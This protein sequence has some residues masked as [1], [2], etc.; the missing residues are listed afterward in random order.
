MHL[1]DDEDEGEGEAELLLP[2]VV[3]NVVGRDYVVVQGEPGHEP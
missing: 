2:I 1:S 3:L